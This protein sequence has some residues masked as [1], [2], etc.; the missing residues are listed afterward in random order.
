MNSR[1]KL[2]GILMSLL[3]LWAGCTQVEPAPT[4]VS[5]TTPTAT[6]LATITAVV[7][8]AERETPTAT[9]TPI[10]SP[11]ATTTP[12]PTATSTPLPTPVRAGPTAT[13]IPVG[14]EV[15]FELVAQVGGQIN[16]FAVSGNYILVGQGPR[17]VVL[18][19]GDPADLTPIGQSDP[20]PGL[21]S[22]LMVQGETAVFTAGH[23][24]TSAT[25]PSR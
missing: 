18:D 2:P 7:S 3:W 20:L 11:T 4:A 17:L 6:V 1:H 22:N 15:S 14:D 16:S 8:L 9:F 13:P 25:P 5:Q 12:L 21:V 10:P 23:L 19:A 24:G